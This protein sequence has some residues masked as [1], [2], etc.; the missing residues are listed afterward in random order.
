MRKHN[1]CLRCNSENVLVLKVNT[2]ISLNGKEE[3]NLYTGCI[4]QKIYKPSDAFVCKDC[5]HVE[6]FLDPDYINK[7]S[8]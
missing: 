5:G 7:Q 2:S 3:K 1:T 8:M 4:T 6:F